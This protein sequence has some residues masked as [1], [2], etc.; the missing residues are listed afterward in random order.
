MYKYLLWKTTPVQY[1]VDKPGSRACR[2]SSLFFTVE[3]KP[4]SVL[5]LERS[6]TTSRCT[7]FISMLFTSVWLEIRLHRSRVDM[8]C[9]L[10]DNYQCKYPAA[11]DSTI[12]V[13]QRQLFVN[14]R[15]IKTSVFFPCAGSHRVKPRWVSSDTRWQQFLAHFAVGN[16]PT[17]AMTSSQPISPKQWHHHRN[18]WERGVM[19]HLKRGLMGDCSRS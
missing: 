1:T 5:Q 16:G 12:S 7:T 3:L 8:S 10:W 18:P 2:V 17:P 14:H 9:S 11:C 19:H 13:K 4:S 6:T 15:K